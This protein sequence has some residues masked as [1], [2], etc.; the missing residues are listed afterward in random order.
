M[1]EPTNLAPVER[2]ERGRVKSGGLNPGGFTAEERKARDAIRLWLVSDMLETG[3]AAYAACLADKNPV[4]VKDFMDRVAGKVKESVSV[5]D[6]N[7]NPLT[8]F[9]GKTF[10]LILDFVSKLKR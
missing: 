8:V 7:G 2:D 4:I 10:A 6:A 3:K 1:T 5:T 9:D